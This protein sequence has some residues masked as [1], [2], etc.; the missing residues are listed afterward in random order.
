MTTHTRADVLHIGYPK[1]ASTFLVGFLQ[2]HP[3]ITVDQFHLSD[4][5]KPSAGALAIQQK[6]CADKIHISKDENV[7]ESVCVVGDLN[8]WQRNLYVPGAW[9]HVKNDVVVHPAEAA[10]RL[11][12]VHS[13]AKVLIVI[14]EQT[15]WMQSVYK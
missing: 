13:D 14:R 4:L 2:K 7:A 10:L 3:Q 8:N 5:L 9:D 15:D 11:H 1:A 6:P 12:K